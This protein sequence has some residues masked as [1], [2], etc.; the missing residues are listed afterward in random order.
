[1]LVDNIRINDATITFEC[2]GHSSEGGKSDEN[3]YEGG[4]D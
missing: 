4:D 2:C 3:W 1:M